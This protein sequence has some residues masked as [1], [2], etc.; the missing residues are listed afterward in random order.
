MVRSIPFSFLWHFFLFLGVST[1]PIYWTF[2]CPLVIRSG[3]WPILNI[4]STPIVNISWKCQQLVLSA[5]SRSPTTY[6]NS[7]VVNLKTISLLASHFVESIRLE[8]LEIL[9]SIAYES[10]VPIFRF[11]VVL[12]SAQ[13]T[14]RG[15]LEV[16]Q[17]SWKSSSWQ[18]FAIWRQSQARWRT[19]LGIHFCC[20]IELLNA[21]NCLRMPNL[22]SRDYKKLGW[23]WPTW[24]TT[25]KILWM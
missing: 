23:R 20:S 2:G 15:S 12:I 21:R 6:L 22:D 1:L 18:S 8:P 3:T 4:S 17:R 10:Q 7:V 19:C 11:T 5:F 13:W 14:T 24:R 16:A 25:T 9:K